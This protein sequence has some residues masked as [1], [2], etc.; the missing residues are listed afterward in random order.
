MI[1]AIAAVVLMAGGA[2]LYRSV[3]A[4][5]FALGVFLTSALNVG[6]VLMLERTVNRTIN[7]DDPETGKNFVRLQ[8]LLRYFLTAAILLVAGLTP[9]VSVWGALFGLFTLQISVIFVR[10][11]RFDES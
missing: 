10:S 11:M 1:I 8:F 4:I 9:F 3:E 2:V 6:K 5:P 7:M